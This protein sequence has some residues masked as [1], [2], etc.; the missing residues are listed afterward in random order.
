M[1]GFSKPKGAAFR[2][3]A[4]WAMDNE[5]AAN[6]VKQLK[7]MMHLKRMQLVQALMM[8]HSFCIHLFEAL[9]ASIVLGP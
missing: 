3:A 1:R 5:N 9:A 4:S 2:Q 7:R 6:G 8:S